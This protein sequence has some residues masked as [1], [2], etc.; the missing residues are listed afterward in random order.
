LPSGSEPIVPANSGAE[1]TVRRKSA[2]AT[3]ALVV[4]GIMAMLA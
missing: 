3:F 1:A 2:V 4:C